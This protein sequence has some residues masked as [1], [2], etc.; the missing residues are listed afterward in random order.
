MFIHNSS[1]RNRFAISAV[2]VSAC[3][4]GLL[5]GEVSPRIVRDGHTYFVITDRDWNAAEA[6]AVS[7]GGHLATI[8]DEAEN[9]FLVSAF[10]GGETW[11][12]LNDRDS[13][14]TFV[15]TSG[16]PVT[17]TNWA[18]GEPS[19]STGDENAA[20]LHSTGQW[21][22]S[23]E[24]ESRPGIVEVPLADCNANGIDDATDIA[25][26]TS[27]DCN[28]DGKPDE[29]QLN[30]PTSYSI[31]VN[32]SLPVTDTS[33][34]ATYTFI[35]PDAGAVLDVDVGIT[36]THTWVSDLVITIS[37]GGTSV[38]LFSHQCGSENNFAGTVWDDEGDGPIECI[39]G[40]K[41]IFVPL[42][43]LSAFDGTE[44][45]GD[46][47]MT[48]VDT[49][50]GDDGSLSAW[51]LDIEILGD[52]NAN[53]T[54]D[55]C[56]TAAGASNDCNFN[57]RPDECEPDC[58]GNGTPDDCDIADV[59]SDDCNANGTP[60]ECEPDC[61]DNGTPDECDIAAG[62]SDDQNGNGTP[63][64][65]DLADNDCNANGTPDELELTRLISYSMPVS[66]SLPVANTLPPAMDTF[67]MGETGIVQDVNVGMT[68]DHSWVSDV[69]IT[70]S[71]GDTTVTLFSHQCG[72]ENNFSGTVWDD[73]AG[74]TIAC[75]SGH[76][77]T[78]QPF[79]PLSAFDGM[80]ASGEW[81][82]TVT[83]TESGDNG[84]WTSWSLS[85]E[86]SGTV[87]G[88]DYNADGIV[89]LGDY[90]GLVAC[91]A[92]P[93]ATP[94]PPVAACASTCLAAFDFDF[95]GD[96]DLADCTAFLVAFAP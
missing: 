29:C 8:N 76:V 2:L 49:E 1:S 10:A 64:E 92:G 18:P 16:E 40:H 71:H 3:T 43:P 77:G 38:T 57:E 44:A 58:N 73:E 82:M 54:P 12:G 31:P 96:V 14:G 70:V 39:S 91:L 85:L 53:G 51:S 7:L 23:N 67:L 17:Y 78:F 11:I 79:S 48:V 87:T 89:G 9:I 42:A 63:D 19:D 25:A 34:P 72:G 13:E 61:N 15:W 83:D 80:E 94:N 45:A 74:E 30:G 55:D 93:G 65:C 33:L 69:V 52:C 66:P 22:D 56:D 62:T 81:T 28:A 41:G 46:W 95:D 60:D 90:L 86:L 5:A 59:T 88:G 75:T 20:Y 32:P 27:D 4:S 26:G 84:S 47:T 6:F 21:N 50:S 35:V 37:H 36:M 68:L 24:S